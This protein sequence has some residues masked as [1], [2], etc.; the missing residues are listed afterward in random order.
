[1]DN[2]LNHPVT[3]MIASGYSALSVYFDFFTSAI[4]FLSAGIGLVIGI[5]SLANTWQKFKNR[6]K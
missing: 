4:G 5:L 3:G 2:A 1:M 6:K